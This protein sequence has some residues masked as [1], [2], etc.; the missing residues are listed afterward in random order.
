MSPEVAVISFEHQ[1][2]ML[3]LDQRLNWFDLLQT[4]F[5]YPFSITLFRKD[6]KKSHF[7]ESYTDIHHCSKRI[8]QMV[9]CSICF[10]SLKLEI[11]MFFYV[12][13][14]ARPREN[15]IYLVFFSYTIF[16]DWL[17]YA[18]KVRA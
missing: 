3:Y 5:F 13:L 6:P 17:T 18:N 7:W 1:S 4:F 11:L 14:L 8:R 10:I 15:T 16:L 2:R 12:K 9:V